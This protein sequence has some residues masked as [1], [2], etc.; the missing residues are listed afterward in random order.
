MEI[1]EQNP[2]EN[3]KAAPLMTVT[4]EKDLIDVPESFKSS[5]PAQ[6]FV[7]ARSTYTPDTSCHFR[8]G[9]AVAGQGTLFIDGTES[10][11]LWTSHPPKTDET[12]VFNRV[13]MERFADR[14][15]VA[16]K[17]FEL[18]LLLTN[19]SLGRAVG[20]AATLTARLG[21][22]EI[23]DEDEEIRQAAELAKTVD[24]PIIMTGLSMDYEYE[25][26]DRKTLRLPRRTDEMIEAVLSANPNA[27]GEIQ[28]R[29]RHMANTVR[30]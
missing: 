28:L 18:E 1:F 8:F 2:T 19:T 25:G 7:R 23:L 17:P 6:F 14:D 20:T 26:S 5:L 10:I 24:C 11:D 27:V 9:L 4:T 30:L 15:A 29:D 3:N 13:S 16:G 12:P 22:F 21:G